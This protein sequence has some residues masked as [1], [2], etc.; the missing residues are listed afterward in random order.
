MAPVVAVDGRE[1]ILFV[2]QL[3]FRPSK[4]TFMPL[5]V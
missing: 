1:V 3:H 5:A 2:R 4:L